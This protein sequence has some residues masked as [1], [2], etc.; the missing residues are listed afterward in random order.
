LEDAHQAVSRIATLSRIADRDVRPEFDPTWIGQTLEADRVEAAD[1][2]IGISMEQLAYMR[3]PDIDGHSLQSPGDRAGDPDRGPGVGHPVSGGEMA[4][5]PPALQIISMPSAR[6]S[7]A[8]L[9]PE[10]G[11]ACQSRLI[12]A[13]TH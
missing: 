4:T 10:S 7:L 11:P 2:V 13:A 12:Q 6:A 1:G 3:S 8:Q 5:D 9:L